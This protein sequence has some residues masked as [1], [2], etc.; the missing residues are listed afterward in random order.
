V[1]VAEGVELAVEVLEAVRLGSRVWVGER[2]GVR[3]L[4]RTGR[5]VEVLVETSSRS[6]L[7][8]ARNKLPARHR[9]KVIEAG[10]PQSKRLPKPVMPCERFSIRKDGPLRVVCGIAGLGRN[11]LYYKAVM[12]ENTG[13]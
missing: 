4:V 6:G 10:K 12:G 8:A 11:R 13:K 3:L 9:N 2:V 7:Q 5:G 1:T